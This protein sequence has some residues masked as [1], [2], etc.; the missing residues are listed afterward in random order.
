MATLR[1][2]LARVKSG[3]GQAVALVGEPAIG[4]SWLLNEFRRGL[5][6]GQA[7]YLEGRCRSYGRTRPY[8]PL[9]DIVRQYCGI[10]ETDS[11]EAI[12]AKVSQRLQENAM[13]SEE[14]VAYLLHLLGVQEQ[15]VGSQC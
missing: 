7:T 3:Q 13:A 6:D 5:R 4:K 14:R 2:R 8:V 11:A 10:I 1:S 12:A 15:A 9:R